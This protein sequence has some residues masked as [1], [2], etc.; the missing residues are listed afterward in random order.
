MDV[1]QDGASR[2]NDERTR[3][4]YLGHATVLIEL[5]GLRILTDPILR[6]RITFL[7][8]RKLAKPK[9]DLYRSVDVILLSHLHYDHLD[10]PSLRRVGSH[11]PLLAPHG[12]GDFLRSKGMTRVEEMRRE[13]VVEVG[14]VRIRATYADHRARRHPFGPRAE[15]LGYLI[16]GDSS[17]YFPGDTDLFPEMD[18]LADD[19]DVALMPVWGW[20]PTL[21]DG[22]LDPRRA[23]EALRMLQPRLAV[24]IHWGAFYPA[25]LGF[26]RSDFLTLPPVRFAEHAAEL[27]PE[28]MVRIVQ[29][30]ETLRLRPLLTSIS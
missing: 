5:D 25:G 10:P 22:H 27:A 8:R 7:R 17:V 26:L 6:N 16:E 2:K 15:C 18:Q 9:P 19:L 30:G 21:G 13:D 1:G 12:S 24:P 23:A 20:G 4:T 11:V 28:V 29:P 3:I 14:P